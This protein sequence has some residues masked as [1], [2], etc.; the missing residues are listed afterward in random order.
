MISNNSKQMIDDA[1]RY[2]K[3][4][5]IAAIVFMGVVSFVGWWYQRRTR[6]LFTEQV[7]KIDEDVGSKR[8]I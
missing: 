3:P 5:A 7:M 4:L 8:R 2:W 6:D 1:Q